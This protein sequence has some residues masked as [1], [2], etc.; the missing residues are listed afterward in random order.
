MSKPVMHGDAKPEA[1]ELQNERA[2]NESLIRQLHSLTTPHLA[3]GCLRAGVSVRC[4][5]WSVRPLVA[6]MR[7]AGRA[8]PVRH[9][10]SIDVF[11]EA[12][13]GAVTGEVMVIDNEGRTDE[14]CVG[15][16]VA[17]E[18]KAAG[19]A[20]IVI[21]GLHRDH[22]ELARIG[23]SVFSMGPLPTGPQ[24][25]AP[26]PADTFS[27]ATV[28]EHRVTAD[29]IVAADGNGVLFLPGDRL[30]DIIAAAAACRE[31]EQRQLGAMVA[32]RNYRSQVWF[33]DY[34]ARRQAD[35]TYSF[36][37]HLKH[38]EAAGEV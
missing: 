9:V 11:F 3:D 38:V 18:A 22:D 23:F 8:R 34:L 31:T 21:W 13:E 10:G 37:Q 1:T 15:D 2:M 6:G 25:L 26:R 35:G 27:A 14:A 7:C 16:I 24:R 30:G 5:L 12:L 17:L 29:D 20:G 19:I 28:G 32:G 33:A 4:A 36:R